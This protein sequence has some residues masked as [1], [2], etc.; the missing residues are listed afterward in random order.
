MTNEAPSKVNSYSVHPYYAV[1]INK[2]G[3]TFETLVNDLHHY[4]YMKKGGFSSLVPL[5]LNILKSG[6]QTMK[7][8]VFPDQ[9]K[10]R[11][12][13]ESYMDIEIRCFKDV[14]DQTGDFTSVL[15]FSLPKEV[16]EKGLP[17]FEIELPFVASV[18]YDHSERLVNAEV[19]KKDKATEDKIIAKYNEVRKLIEKLD[20]GALNK[21]TADRDNILADVFYYTPDQV[22]ELAASTAGDLEPDAKVQPVADYQIVYYAGGKVV[23][24]ERRSDKGPILH[25]ILNAGK[26][27]K[28]IISFDMMFYQPKGAADLKAF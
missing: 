23:S 24:L 5:N 14:A 9:G 21:L 15:K 10:T 11:F 27:N 16:K 19:L 6:K 1:Q 25:S 7:L 2:G 13:D 26:P 20:A 12:D 28:E 4:S 8:K 22:K 18:P 17:Y 3:C